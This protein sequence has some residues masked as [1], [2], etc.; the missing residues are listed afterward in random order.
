MNYLYKIYYIVAG[1]IFAVIFYTV[2]KLL[3]KKENIKFKKIL[4]NIPI[5]IGIIN[6]IITIYLFIMIVFIHSSFE[7]T[8]NNCILNIIYEIFSTYYHIFA[9]PISVGA[10]TLVILLNKNN[11]LIG[12]KYWYGL[13]L[14]IISA[15][16]LAI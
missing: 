2:Y 14:N 13:I 1:I 12:F 5:I 16:A 3:I 6:I 15:I 11:N 7:I 9:S 10:L 4:I 8:F